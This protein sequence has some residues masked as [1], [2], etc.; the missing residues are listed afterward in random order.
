MKLTPSDMYSI[1]AVVI[2]SQ[3]LQ[4]LTSFDIFTTPHAAPASGSCHC[5]AKTLST[6]LEQHMFSKSADDCKCSYKSIISYIL[7]IIHFLPDS[8]K[9]IGEMWSDRKTNESLVLCVLL[10]M[11]LCS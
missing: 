5:H 8:N 4:I 11:G 10:Q 7:Q 3:D 9:Q 6:T 2:T 1:V